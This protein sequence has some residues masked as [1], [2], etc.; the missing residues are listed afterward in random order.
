MQSRAARLSLM[1]KKGG[2]RQR[3]NERMNPSSYKKEKEQNKLERH[4][5]ADRIWSRGQRVIQISRRRNERCA[6]RGNNNGG[7][8]TYDQ[9][10]DAVWLIPIL[11]PKTLRNAA[12]ER[13]ASSEASKQAHFVISASL[14]RSEERKRGRAK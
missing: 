2:H 8:Q 11:R 6:S 5:C 7:R 13:R 12:R 9:D 1:R 3:L 4:C 14:S 10:D